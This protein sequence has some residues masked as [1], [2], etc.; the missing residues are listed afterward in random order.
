MIIRLGKCIKFI[1]TFKEPNP[2]IQLDILFLIA[3][4]GAYAGLYGLFKEKITLSNEP[5]FPGCMI[6]LVNVDD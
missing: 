1:Q 2:I 4:I 6:R 3:F 5:W